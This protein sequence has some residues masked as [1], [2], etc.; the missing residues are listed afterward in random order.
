[1]ELI[2]ASGSRDAYR[3]TLGSSRS[4]EDIQIT[5]SGLIESHTEF[6]LST[7]LYPALFV[8]LPSLIVFDFKLPQSRQVL[9]RKLVTRGPKLAF[10]DEYRRILKLFPLELLGN[11]TCAQ[12]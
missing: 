6:V 9:S 1:M 8:L 4:L 12:P 7:G 5:T 3:L 10:R 11:S 2:V